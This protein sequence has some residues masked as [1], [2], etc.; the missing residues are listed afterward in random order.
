[1]SQ[2]TF[3]KPGAIAPGSSLDRVPENENPVLGSA[4]EL[5]SSPYDQRTRLPIY[6]HRDKLLY[7]VEKYGVTII[8]GQ[9]GCGKTT[10]L[11]QFLYEAQWASDGRVIACTQPRRVAATSVATR[12]AQEV[13]TTLG[14]EV[15]YT[16][17]FEDVS[18]KE[19]TRILYLTD[20][21]LFRELLVDPLLSR[22]SVIMVDEVHERSVYTDLL[23]GMLKKI[24][25]KRPELRL[26]VS[27]A[28][29][30][31]AYFLNYF[32]NDT[33]SDE[34]T[35]ISLEGRMYPVQV[36]Y[37][38]EPVPDYVRAA[39][40]LAWDINVQRRPGDILIFLTGREDIDRCLDELSERIPLLPPNAPRMILIPLHAGLT[41]DEQL[42]AFLP[43]EKGTRK[44]IVSTN[45]AEA[46][47]TI[48]GIRY[49]IDSGFVKIRV[50]NPTAS[51]SS[52]VVV[53]TSK[54]AATQR[55]GRAGRTSNGVCYRLYTQAAYDALPAATPPEISRTDL[56]SLILQLKALGVDDL[57]KFPW[58]TPP[59]AESVL[60]A[61]EALSASGL[62]TDSGHL[63]HTGSKIAEYP[64]EHNI[65]KMLFAS[66][67]FKCGEEILTI[68]AMISVQNVF[69]IPDGAPGALAELE[70]RK[71]TAEEGDH[72]TLLNAYNAFIRYGQSSSWCKSH[73]LSFRA[74]SRAVSIR[75]QLKKYMIRFKLPIISCEGDAK[76][77]RQCLV[78]GYWQNSARLQPDSTYLATHGNKILH[79]HPSS[80]LFNRSSR[81]KW[82]IYHE[83]TE[84][85]QTQVNILT[86]IDPDWLLDYGYKYSMK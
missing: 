5:S 37:I 45:I 30:D 20:G 11:P 83:I 60:R 82:I 10:Q 75:A 68:A 44:I 86:E 81:P 52:L 19:R 16:I 8:V 25:R 62:I 42:K 38:D 58:V 21:M 34:A 43:A 40:Q 72:L 48:D 51:M 18:D 4:P 84:T 12:V 14:H 46:S 79:V 61:L 74:M 13:G 28:T 71:F 17:R 39:A 29:M 1:M 36:A 77:L 63:T 65:A 23:L 53:P 6:K 24:R 55:A 56:T 54:A 78:S 2:L 67:D 26:I 59:P 32:T 33:S 80:V 27:S 73:A 64:I 49:V 70:R 69:V 9:T 66:E 85:Q 31:A 15:G 41:T 76:R 47:V 50:Y 7:S 57:M 22:Y 35:V 3:W